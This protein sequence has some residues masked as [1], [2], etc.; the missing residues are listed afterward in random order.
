MELAK[1]EG[2]SRHHGIACLCLL[3]IMALAACGI[4][5][6]PFVETP[7]AYSAAG[8]IVTQ[9]LR[10][11][12]NSGNSGTTFRGYSLYYRCYDD[13]TR[14]DTDRIAIENLAA[15]LNVSP[16]SVFNSLRSTYQFRHLVL[17]TSTVDPPDPVFAVTTPT[18]AI[19]YFLSLHAIDDWTLQTTENGVSSTPAVVDRDVADPATKIF[20]MSFSADFASGDLDYSGSSLFPEGIITGNGPYIVLFAIGF[21]FDTSSSSF[22]LIPSLPASFGYSINMQR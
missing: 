8:S 6:I 17:Q 11:D 16:L 21:G 2:R 1:E 4:E 10:F 14:A 20:P 5:T 13:Q 19:S 22:S 3:S 7:I 15:A 9:P 12:H 18:D